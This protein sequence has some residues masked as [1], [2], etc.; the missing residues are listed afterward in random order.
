[1]TF[2]IYRTLKKRVLQ[3]KS[4]TTVP[5]LPKY[6]IQLSRRG[7]DQRI[8]QTQF[9]HNKKGNHLKPN[10]SKPNKTKPL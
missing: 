10:Q 5:V 3:K 2:T 6:F 9:T 1:M 4:K 7:K 8:S